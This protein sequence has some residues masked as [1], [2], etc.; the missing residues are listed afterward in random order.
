MQDRILGLIICY[1]LLN[2][3]QEGIFYEANNDR[4]EHKESINSGN[5][6]Y[7]YQIACISGGYD[8]VGRPETV[9][10]GWSGQCKIKWNV[11]STLRRFYR[12]L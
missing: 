9:Y 12:T 5:T 7:T 1:A 4:K 10:F 2:K 6:Y 11:C 3:E 8:H